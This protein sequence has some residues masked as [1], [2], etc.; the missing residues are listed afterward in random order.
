MEAELE[1]SWLARGHSCMQH[2]SLLLYR[3]LESEVAP[4]AKQWPSASPVNVCICGAKG[5][6]ATVNHLQ[7]TGPNS[8]LTCVLRNTSRMEIFSRRA[9][10]VRDEADICGQEWVELGAW[11]SFLSTNFHHCC[12]DCNSPLS[13]DCRRDAGW[14]GGA[15]NL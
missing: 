1:L 15:L 4:A 14:G 5:K 12:I 10:E 2:S 11:I 8:L 13:D 6:L 9:A 7:T 3:Q